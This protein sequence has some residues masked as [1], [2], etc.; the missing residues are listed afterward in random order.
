MC[1]KRLKDKGLMITDH[2]VHLTMPVL[3]SDEPSAHSY[4][5]APIHMR[6]LQPLRGDPFG[7]HWSTQ[8][9]VMF[10]SQS[11]SS[12]VPRGDV[13]P[14]PIGSFGPPSKGFLVSCSIC[15]SRQITKSDSDYCWREGKGITYGT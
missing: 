12:H 13:S 5:D 7:S 4:Q 3:S 2:S 10:G 1:K 6:F 14:L 11:L 9:E 15:P 8:V